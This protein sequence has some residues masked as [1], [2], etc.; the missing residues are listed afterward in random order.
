VAQFAEALVTLA[1]KQAAAAKR[2]IVCEIPAATTKALLI[3]PRILI[4]IATEPDH[5]SVYG[6]PISFAEE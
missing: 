2:V 3:L 4:N 5:A 6:L 1:L